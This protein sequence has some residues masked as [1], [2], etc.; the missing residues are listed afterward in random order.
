V[1]WRVIKQGKERR[2]WQEEVHACL[3]GE[4]SCFERRCFHLYVRYP[5]KTK[6][7]RELKGKG[8]RIGRNV[9]ECDGHTP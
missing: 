5:K 4:V 2:S 1:K 3:K 7:K 6:I 9:E 8:V